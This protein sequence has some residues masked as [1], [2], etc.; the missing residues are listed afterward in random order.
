MSFFEAKHIHF[1]YQQK[2]VLE[3]VSISIPEGSIV[4]LLGS[5]GAGKSTLMKILLGLLLPAQGE[6][7]LKGTSL[8]A[9]SIKERA[10][11][12]AYVPQSTKI[13]FSFSALEIVLMGRIAFESWFKKATKGDIALAHQAME[14][15]SI[16][17]LA[18]RNYQTLSGGEKQLVLIARS[19]AQ[20]AK[21]LIMDEPIAGL[22]YG[23]QLRLLEA[24]LTLS[25]EGY[26]FLKSTHFP[27]H[28]LLLGGH[29]YAIQDTKILAYGKTNDVITTEL[30]NTLYSTK[31]ELQTTVSG[32][33][34]CVPN[35][36][37]NK[38]V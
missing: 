28:A 1:S 33:H 37:T 17:H 3:D 27:E 15:L 36:I 11:E 30:I 38:E 7:L 14:K 5:N 20:G 16:A 12:I 31:I 9:Y 21:I 4:S 32:Y 34:V 35:F 19:L 25:R 23:N 18:D 10:K 22:D 26:T 8:K 2:N 13:V 6:V 29:T 24:I